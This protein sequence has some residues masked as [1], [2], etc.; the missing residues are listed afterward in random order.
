MS[1]S[2]L[3]S[4]VFILDLTMDKAKEDS[5]SSSV[6]PEALAIVLLRCSGVSQVNTSL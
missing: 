2:I 5:T 6:I 4:F 1:G 3:A